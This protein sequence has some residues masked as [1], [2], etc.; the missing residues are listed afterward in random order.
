MTN[1]TTEARKRRG[2]R[3]R[4]DMAPKVCAVCGATF[5][6]R[7]G[8]GVREY[9]KRRACS[10]ECSRALRSASVSAYH[11][12]RR[13][14]PDPKPCACCGEPFGPA[15]GEP[16]WRFRRRR[17]CSPPCSRRLAADTAKAKRLPIEERIVRLLEEYQGFPLSSFDIAD[18]LGL[19]IYTVRP[20]LTGLHRAGRVTRWRDPAHDPQEGPAPYLYAVAA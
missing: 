14:L 16:A 20:P 5:A 19:S 9:A 7:E 10:P 12:S 8:E 18:E 4:R 17:T 11:A 15:E 6:R 3:P 2:G 1:V 13:A